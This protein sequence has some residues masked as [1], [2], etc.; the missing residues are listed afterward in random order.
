[1]TGDDPYRDLLRD[2]QSRSSALAAWCGR[3]AYMLGLVLDQPGDA[4]ARK[5][6]RETL[7]AYDDEQR[8]RLAETERLQA[9]REGD[10]DQ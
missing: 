7:E 3:L 4:V 8:A 1:M 10:S 5:V 2:E 6:A 9:E